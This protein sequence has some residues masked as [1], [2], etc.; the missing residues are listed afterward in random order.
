MGRTGND[1]SE[2]G[3]PDP[4]RQTH[5]IFSHKWILTLSIQICVF[6]LEYL[7]NLTSGRNFERRETECSGIK[8]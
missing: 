6:Y 2:S 8:N 3:N 1:Y 5:N 7:H 4:E